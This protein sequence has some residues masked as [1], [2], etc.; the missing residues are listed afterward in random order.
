MGLQGWWA[1][2]EEVASHTACGGLPSLP[3]AVSRLPGGQTGPAD[4]CPPRPGAGGSRARCHTRKSAAASPRLAS[5]ARKRTGRT[6]DI[7]WATAKVALTSSSSFP[8]VLQLGETT[9]LFLKFTPKPVIF[10]FKLAGR[11]PSNIQAGSRV[12]RLSARRFS[13]AF[14]GTVEGLFA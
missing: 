8:G 14:N 2:R 11:E 7:V 10:P 5:S 1:Q 12:C 6:T 13:P 4:R 3:S 9:P